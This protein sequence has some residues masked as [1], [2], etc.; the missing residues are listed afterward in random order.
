MSPRVPL[1]ELIIVV[2][3]EAV[4]NYNEVDACMSASSEPLLINM[5]VTV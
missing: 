3:I 1:G 2:S 5:T 4:I